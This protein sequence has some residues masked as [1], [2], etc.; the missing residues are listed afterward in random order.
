MATFEK[1][2]HRALYRCQTISHHE[3]NS[4]NYLRLIVYSSDSA[5]T[6]KSLKYNSKCKQR[7]RI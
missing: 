5:T 4:N 3:S 2:K 6:T 7:R 1:N